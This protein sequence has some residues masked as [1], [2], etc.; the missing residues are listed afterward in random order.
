MIDAR[1]IIDAGLWTWGLVSSAVTVAVAA[2]HSLFLVI[3][4]GVVFLVLG[5]SGAI[6]VEQIDIIANTAG[7]DGD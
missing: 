6:A 4:F 3:V 1:Q 5:V 7:D 2:E